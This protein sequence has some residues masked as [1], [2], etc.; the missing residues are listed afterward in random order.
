MS[1]VKNFTV[2]VVRQQTAI[3]PLQGVTEIISNIFVRQSI[4]IR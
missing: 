4:I 3:V 1:G 2:Q